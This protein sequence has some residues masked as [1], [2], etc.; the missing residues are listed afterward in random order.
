M[1]EFK[2]ASLTG[3]NF[4]GIVDGNVGR[5]RERGGEVVGQT[6]GREQYCVIVR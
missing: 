4:A 5:K 2:T 1:G 3:S 6:L